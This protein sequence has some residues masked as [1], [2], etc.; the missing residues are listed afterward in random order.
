MSWINPKRCW[1]KSIDETRILWRVTLA[2]ILLLLSQIQTIYRYIRIFKPVNN[3]FESYEPWIESESTDFL[4]IHESNRIRLLKS[5]FN[6]ELNR[7]ISFKIFWVLSW[8]NSFFKPFW[9][10]S[11]NNLN[12]I[13]FCATQS[14]YSFPHQ[15]WK[16]ASFEIIEYCLQCKLTLK[17]TPCA[18]FNQNTGWITPLRRNNSYK[19]V[20]GRWFGPTLSHEASWCGSAAADLSGGSPVPL[21]GRRL[22]P[23]PGRPDHLGRLQG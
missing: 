17:L 4:V 18:C 1:I 13:H 19:C 16:P 14:Y 11:K 12:H 23:R 8:I 2:H 7:I 22:P 9:I 6:H 20:A 10:D 15:T 5:H 3:W 21:A